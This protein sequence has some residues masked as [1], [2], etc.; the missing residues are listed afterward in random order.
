MKKQNEIE[1]C[2]KCPYAKP[3]NDY[4]LDGFDRGCD[5][6]CTLA[7]KIIASLLEKE[8]DWELI[9]IPEWCPLEENLK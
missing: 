7:D 3:T 4:S 5:Y 2:G 1:N 8:S 6:K 9:Q